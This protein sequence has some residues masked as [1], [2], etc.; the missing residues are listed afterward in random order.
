MTVYRYSRYETSTYTP[1]P[2][3][4]GERKYLQPRDRITIS[5]IQPSWVLH[6]VEAGDTLDGLA[7]RYSGEQAGSEKLWWMIADINGILWP[8]DLELGSTLIIPVV[9]LQAG[10]L[11]REAAK[12]S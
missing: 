8:M 1:I 3:E 11:V 7:Y 12:T 2:Q 4:C 9:E 6:A 10:Y 5:D